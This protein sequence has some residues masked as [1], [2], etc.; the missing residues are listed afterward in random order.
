M[1]LVL[2]KAQEL[3]ISFKVTD[4]A[5][6]A[7]IYNG[8]KDD[9]QTS[10]YHQELPPYEVSMLLAVCLMLIKQNED[11]EEYV[12]ESFHP[13]NNRYYSKLTKKR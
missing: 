1:A 8:N 5:T 9:F 6:K 4:T 10:A 2:R 7:T 3:K 13:K 11:L 12:E